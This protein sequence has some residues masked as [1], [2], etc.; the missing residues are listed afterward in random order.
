M[1]KLLAGEVDFDEMLKLY[2]LGRQSRFGDNKTP[3]PSI[4]DPMKYYPW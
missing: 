3:K 1:D 2:G 4:L